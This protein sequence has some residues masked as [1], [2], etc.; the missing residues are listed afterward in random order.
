VSEI[1][2]LEYGCTHAEMEE[3]QSLSLRKQLGGGSKW[4]TWVVLILILIGILL[5]FYQQILREVLPAYR[6]YVIA[7]LVVLIVGVTTWKRLARKNSPQRTRVEISE[8]EFVILGPDSRVAMPWSAFGDCLE[9]PKLF[10]LVDRPKGIL[11]VVPK[12]A[13]PS[14]SA[15]DW[16]RAL[17]RTRR[18]RVEPVTPSVSSN[19]RV[20]SSD[21]VTLGFRLGY[22]DYL[23]RT[24]ASYRTWGIYLVV[25][26]MIIGITL[27]SAAHPPPNAVDS[28]V[29]VFFMFEVPFLLVMMAVMTLVIS[30]YTWRLHAKYLLPQELVLSGLSLEFSGE[31]G[32]GM[33][34]WSTYTRY[35]ETRWSF[36][37]WNPRTS[38]WTMLPKRAFASRDDLERCRSLLARHLLKSRW[39]FG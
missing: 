36:I 25:L 37:L 17:V 19:Q 7:G 31:D 1:L 22:R 9:S 6:P 35:K 24:V 2:R 34:P 20:V 33:L 5:A 14:E 26:V 30:V 11:F 16:F 39:F 23:D 21:Q 27:Y 8:T 32:Q 10:A 38:L 12:R 18:S 13:F 4:L 28:A 15:Q 3:A 29:Q